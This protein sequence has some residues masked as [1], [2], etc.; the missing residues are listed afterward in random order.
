MQISRENTNRRTV[1]GV[2]VGDTDV[3]TLVK[4]IRDA[5]D[6]R[7]DLPAGYYFTYG[8]QFEN[9]QAASARLAV[10]VPV[11]L[12]LIFILLYFTFGSFPQA[13]LIFVAIPLSAIGGVWALILRGMP[14][15]I[16]A[17]IGFIA[18]FGVAVLNGIVLVGYFN[19]LKVEGVTDIRQRILRGTRV[20]LR[21]VIMTA[22]VASL[23]FLPMALSESG[24]AEVQRPLATV[25]IGGLV[26]A[27]LLTLV[28]LPIGYSWLEHW[29]RR[30]TARRQLVLLIPFL[31]FA[32]GADAQV[33]RISLPE[34]I[35][36]GMAENPGL[37]AADRLVA[38][39]RTLTELPY[40][41]GTTDVSYNGD[42]LFRRNN[43][44]V[45]QLTVVQRFDHPAAL[46]AANAVQE[47]TVAESVAERQLTAAELRLAVRSLY[48]R[49]QYREAL[50]RHY[51]DLAATFAAYY[52]V[53]ASR[54]NAGA[55]NRLEALRIDAEGQAIN[56]RVEMN[57]LTL[58]SLQQQLA[59]LT[60]RPGLLPADTLSLFTDVPAAPA[61]DGPAVAVARERL[62]GT[63]AA[64][65]VTAAQ[66]LPTFRLGYSAQQYAEGGYLSGLEAGVTLQLFTA[67]TRRRLA[68]GRIDVEVAEARLADTR[69]AYDRDAAEIAAELARSADNAAFY[70]GQE[71]GV[72]AELLRV[73]R[74]NYRAGELNYLEVLDAL[75]TLA[76]IR[77]SRLTATLEQNLAFFRLQY[78]RN[79]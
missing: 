50:A 74:L 27:T 9:L 41:P 53:A 30:R 17:G 70:L 5:L 25:V 39:Q 77:E 78:L 10:A 75:R 73:T 36:L 55:A 2:N 12:A 48:A 57:G 24:G 15:S 38:R 76:E 19:Q 49:L 6:A 31:C 56:Q 60:G 13:V 64:V 45:N 65:D 23:G 35:E 16:S 3:E 52:R 47:A 62:A 71:R 79:E 51:A 4:D 7:L 54:A 66:T 33:Q 43:Q 8:G 21:P 34:A 67:A 59:L 40:A 11:A 22:A 61:A 63:R 26:T 20:R 69:L 68:A 32:W 14:F 46:R 37:R 18:L 42:G 58:E 28:V 1:I 44:L 29:Q 72:I